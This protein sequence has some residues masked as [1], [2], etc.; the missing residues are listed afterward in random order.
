[1]TTTR[2]TS[3]ALHIDRSVCGTVITD[4]A[5]A[6]I[7][8]YFEWLDMRVVCDV[9]LPV[10]LA[11][12]WE[13]PT[14]SGLRMVVLGADLKDASTHWI[15]VIEV[16]GMA[17]PAPMRQRGWLALEVLVHDVYALGEKLANSPFTVLGE[18]RP[19]AVSDAIVAMQ[20][21]GP[22]GET[23]YLTEVRAPV[24]PFRL[25]MP[26]THTAERLFIPVL[27]CPERDTSLP[28]YESLNGN[29]GLRFETRVSALNLALGLDPEKQ[30]PV[31]TLQLA[32]ESLIEIDQ[33]PEHGPT[34]VVLAGLPAGLAMVSFSAS[35]TLPLPTGVRW[36]RATEGGS[37]LALFQGPS[38]EWI[39]LQAD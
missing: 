24:L 17:K 2:S 29:T 13:K 25:P 1:M 38:G 33:V 20:V 36:H 18:P 11:D 28:F 39:E 10:S 7:S 21:A 19:L 37:V 4:D 31:G 15:R 16:P 22:A 34:N 8:D 9:P 26:A 27:S 5:D 35:R 32:G 3:A 14:L 30:R 12:A 6:M 23:L